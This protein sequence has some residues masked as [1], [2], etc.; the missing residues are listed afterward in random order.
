MSNSRGSVQDPAT[1]P[2]PWET[3]FPALM[4]LGLL[5][6]AP[7]TFDKP[8]V[9]EDGGAPQQAPLVRTL[10]C[11]GGAGT[12]VL[13]QICAEARLRLMTEQVM[14]GL[15]A[16]EVGCLPASE[17]ECTRH[18]LINLGR[19]LEELPELTAVALEAF[20][21]THLEAELHGQEVPDEVPQA[22]A[23]HVGC[24]S[25]ESDEPYG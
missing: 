21:A 9:D 11:L 7:E 5:S 1:V 25:L 12:P 8:E 19:L 6:V 2:V 23:Q 3:K 14:L 13:D 17:T 4:G 22:V 15:I 18:R 24:Y 20:A 16:M 10:A